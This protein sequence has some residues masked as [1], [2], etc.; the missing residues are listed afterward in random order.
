MQFFD[1]SNFTNIKQEII[2]ILNDSNLCCDRIN[3]IANFIEHQIEEVQKFKEQLI[4]KDISIRYE[5][6]IR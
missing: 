6:E 2:D 4:E 3:A 5:E 1:I